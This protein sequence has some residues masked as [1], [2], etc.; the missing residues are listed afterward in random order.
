[1]YGMVVLCV[2]HGGPR[3]GHGGLRVGH[4]GPTCMAWWSSCK[5]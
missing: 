4:N 2:W 1:M 3:E 5:A